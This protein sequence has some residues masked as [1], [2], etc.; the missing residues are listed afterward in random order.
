MA[1]TGLMWPDWMSVSRAEVR[2]M[3]ML[4]E[5]RREG[6]R[7]WMRS[8]SKRRSSERQYELGIPLAAL[9]CAEAHLLL[10]YSS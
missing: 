3:P 9:G 1:K 7:G 2:C 10:L 8:R 6:G 4:G 5:G